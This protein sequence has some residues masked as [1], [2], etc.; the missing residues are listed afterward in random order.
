LVAGY[1]CNG[2]KAREHNDKMVAGQRLIRLRRSIF[3]NIWASD[4]HVADH[5]QCCHTAQSSGFER[6][7]KT[8]PHHHR[9]KATLD[10]GK[11]SPYDVVVI[12]SFQSRALR[13]FWQR[14]KTGAIDP[15]WLKRVRTILTALEI[16]KAPGA[17]DLPGLGFH[18][19]KGNK[20][21]RYAVTVSGNWRITFAWSGMDATDVELED[22]HGN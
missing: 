18:G 8:V 20:K 14:G 17:L 10:T 15:Q 13:N 11:A 9:S 4:L 5:R 21:G 12:K 6:G 1:L 2:H 22:Y 16:A 3:L 7:T 19:L